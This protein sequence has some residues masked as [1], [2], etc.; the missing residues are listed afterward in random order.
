MH[1]S[2]QIRPINNISRTAKGIKLKLPGNVQLNQIHPVHPYCQKTETAIFHKEVGT[3]RDCL[4]G[5]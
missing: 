1:P 2:C 4:G 5:R 3:F